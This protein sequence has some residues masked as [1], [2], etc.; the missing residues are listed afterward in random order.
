MLNECRTQ[1]ITNTNEQALERNELKNDCIISKIHQGL[2][3]KKRMQFRKIW[4]HR[5]IVAFP[6][7]SLGFYGIFYR[8]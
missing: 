1:Q 6:P 4:Q 2:R 8:T 5:P 3:G 7:G